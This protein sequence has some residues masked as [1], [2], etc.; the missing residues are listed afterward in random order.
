M[1]NEKEKEINALK[2]RLSSVE[3][4]LNQHGTK[5]EEIEKDL[6][7]KTM[8]PKKFIAHRTDSELS[9][10]YNLTVNISCKGRERKQYP[11]D[12]FH[13]GWYYQSYHIFYHSGENEYVRGEKDD[14]FVLF[15][16]NDEIAGCEPFTIK[17]M[18][19]EWEYE[20]DS[21]LD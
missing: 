8:S 5:I 1:D 18:D 12:E 4:I 11:E 6:G 21:A 13:K 17:V 19:M 15:T 3:K 7:T 16:E 20:Y 14:V 2:E 9:N 10:Y